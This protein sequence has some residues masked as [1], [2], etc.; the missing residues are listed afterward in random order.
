[1]IL[2]LMLLGCEQDFYLPTK[3]D[4]SSS[5]NLHIFNFGGESRED[6]GEYKQEYAYFYINDQLNN[7]FDI[8]KVPFRVAPPSQFVKENAFLQLGQ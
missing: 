5:A 1:M 4:N 7:T 8:T 6:K 3:L 2:V